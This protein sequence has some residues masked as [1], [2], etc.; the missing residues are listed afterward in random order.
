MWLFSQ[1]GKSY[2]GIEGGARKVTRTVEVYNPANDRWEGRNP[3]HE[4]RCMFVACCP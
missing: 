3:M 1:L 4:L 2:S